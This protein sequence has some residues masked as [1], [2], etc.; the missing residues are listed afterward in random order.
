MKWSKVILKTL[1]WPL[2]F[3]ELG[4]APSQLFFCEF[5]QVFQNI[6]LRVP[7][8]HYFSK[9]SLA[10]GITKFVLVYIFSHRKIICFRSLLFSIL[11]IIHYSCANESGVIFDICWFYLQKYSSF[12]HFPVWIIQDKRRNGSSQNTKYSAAIMEKIKF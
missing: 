3:G 6:S 4:R 9:V 2:F 7:L 10:K 1:S 8:D 5:W 12:H 11:E